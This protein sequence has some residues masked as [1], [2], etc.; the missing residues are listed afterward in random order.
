MSTFGRW[1]KTSL[2]FRADTR[3]SITRTGCRTLAR[4]P[5]IH[6]LLGYIIL[7]DSVRVGHGQQRRNH[8]FRPKLVDNLNSR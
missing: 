7:G 3:L 5:G 2:G 4:T 6:I 8:G 1:N